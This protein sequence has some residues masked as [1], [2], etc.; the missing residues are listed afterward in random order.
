MEPVPKMF[1]IL[2]DGPAGFHSAKAI[3]ERDA[4]ADLLMITQESMYPYNRPMLTKALEQALPES[5]L[6]IKNKEWYRQ[7][8]VEVATQVQVTRIDL[9]RK[10]VYLDDGSQ[11]S[12]DRLIYALGARNSLPPIPGAD[13]PHVFSIRSIADADALRASLPG[14]RQAV[15]I[16]GGVLGLEAAWSLHRAGISVDIVEFMPRIMARQLDAEASRMVSG[17]VESHGIRVRCAAQTEQITAQEVRLKDGTRLPCG[18]VIISAGVLPNSEL[19]RDAGLR[20]DR[21]VLV[22]AFLGTKD[23]DVYAC[24]D[25]VQIPGVLSGIWAQAV[26]M[27]ECAGANAAGER[28]VFQAKTAAMTLQAFDSSVIALGDNG[29][30]SGKSYTCLRLKG[31]EGTAET[32]YFVDGRLVGVIAI[33]DLKRLGYFTKAVEEGRSEESVRGELGS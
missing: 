11:V 15:I 29:Y 4:A 23:P 27:G 22:D 2:G 17:L 13:L 33:G 25:C 18:L 30:D 8:R 5:R 7:S 12:Y 9:A 10:L 14:V 21:G 16:G 31:E 19:A 1:V 28:Q 24:G 6:L 3:R 32:F 20:T 26:R